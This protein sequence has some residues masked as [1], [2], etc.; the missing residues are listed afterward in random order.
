M[1]LLKD[2]PFPLLQFYATAPY[3]CSYLPGR[4]ARSQVATPSHLIDARIYSELVHS[5]FRRSGIFTYRPYCD[6][7]RAC[8]PVR[9]PVAR[10]A[11]NRAQRR[12]SAR[13]AGLEARE[14]PLAFR[15]EHYTLY[16][17][18]Q[19]SRHSGGGMDQD[20]REQYAHF[21]LQSHVDSRLVEFRENGLL[22]MACIVDVLTD[23]LSSVYTFFDPDVADASYGTCG[24][25]WQIAQCRTLGLPHLYLGYWIGESRKMAYKANF[26]PIEGRIGGVWRELD[27]EDLRRR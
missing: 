13:H 7:C 19:S 23:G 16:Q 18:Y 20:S 21:L 22:R 5:G 24:I 17:R 6:A 2:L 15:E 25:L 11:P 9:L 12:A 8:V 4:I 3:A 1:S 10:F 14:L 26:R 27:D